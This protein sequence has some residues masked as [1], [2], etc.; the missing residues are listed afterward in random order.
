MTPRP[1]FF[2]AGVPA[3][4]GNHRIARVG[5]FARI[6]D[7]NRKLSPWRRSIATAA[8]AAGWTGR[9]VLD[10]G[11]ALSCVFVFRRPAS[12]FGKRGLKP[13]APMMPHTTGDDHDKLVRAVCDALTGL[14]YRDDRRVVCCNDLKMWGEVE[15]VLISVAPMLDMPGS[16]AHEVRDVDVIGEPQLKLEA[17]AGH[18]RS[19]WPDEPFESA[20]KR[21]PKFD[22]KTAKEIA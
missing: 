22:T 9:E 10:C 20:W 12:H 16:V 21:A 3:G 4:Q 2:V 14:V 8:I 6:Y 18:L 5:K 11:V 19:A 15:G 17:F 13:S 1:T 7:A